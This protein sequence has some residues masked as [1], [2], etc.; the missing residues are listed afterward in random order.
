MKLQF[1]N[2][3]G[4]LIGTWEEVAHVQKSTFGSKFQNN[5]IFQQESKVSVNFVN[6]SSINGTTIYNSQGY[7]ETTQEE[8]SHIKKSNFCSKFQNNDIL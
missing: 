8:V 6:Y 7:A 3:K 5:D 1:T 2:P 4:T